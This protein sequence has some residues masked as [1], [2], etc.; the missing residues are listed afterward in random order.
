MKKLRVYLAVLL[1]AVTITAC[2]LREGKEY[3]VQLGV[4]GVYMHIKDQYTH[5]IT[6]LLWPTVCKWDKVCV[7]N[8]LHDQVKISG[9]G[10]AEWYTA[11]HYYTDLQ[12]AMISS[13]SY[14]TCLVLHKDIWFG[15]NWQTAGCLRNTGGGGGGGGSWDEPLAG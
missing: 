15:L 7:G 2:T 1:A 5:S 12:N 14:N 10:A 4:S 3:V 8:Y 11:T 9:W 6:H 13:A